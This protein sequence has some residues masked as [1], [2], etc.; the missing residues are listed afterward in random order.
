[1]KRAST[2]DLLREQVNFQWNINKNQIHLKS[3]VYNKYQSNEI[4]VQRLCNSKFTFLCLSNW[5]TIIQGR[6]R[7]SCTQLLQV[8]CLRLVYGKCKW[9]SAHVCHIQFSRSF[10]MQHSCM[11]IN[12]PKI[13]WMKY[14]TNIYEMQKQKWRWQKYSDIIRSGDDVACVR[15]FI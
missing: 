8:Q 5:L 1:M 7:F 13:W 12:L 3:N 10:D 2:Q 11:N 14:R 6:A 9:P 4:P 15:A